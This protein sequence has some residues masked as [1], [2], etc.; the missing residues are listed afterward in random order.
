MK[1]LVDV[2]RELLDEAKMILGEPTLTATITAALTM[3][4]RNARA[5]D[6]LNYFAELPPED[7]QAM[8][9]ARDHW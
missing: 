1:T 5:H 4:V 7:R 9:D 6:T 8:L 2:D 3:V